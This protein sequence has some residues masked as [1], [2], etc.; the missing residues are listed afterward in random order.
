MVKTNT[1]Q[2]FAD[3]NTGVSRPSCEKEGFGEK[4]EGRVIARRGGLSPEGQRIAVKSRKSESLR[5]VL[6]FF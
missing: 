1:P 5:V 6:P 3:Q 2:V 4:W